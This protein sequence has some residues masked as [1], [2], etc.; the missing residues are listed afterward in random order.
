MEKFQDTQQISSLWAEAG[1]LAPVTVLHFDFKEVLQV[2]RVQ[3][4]KKTLG[5]TA[6]ACETLPTYPPRPSPGPTG[7]G[8][9]AALFGRCGHVHSV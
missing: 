4:T 5:E 2:T 9:Q 3:V 7:L 6:G 8:E 1:F